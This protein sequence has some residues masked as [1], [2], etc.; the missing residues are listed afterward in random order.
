M[1]VFDGKTECIGFIFGID[2]ALYGSLKLF[3][4][5]CSI[6]SGSVVWKLGF[7]SCISTARCN[8]SGRNNNEIKL[9]LFIGL[10][11]CSY[12]LNYNSKNRKSQKRRLLEH[13]LHICCYLYPLLLNKIGFIVECSTI[14]VSYYFKK[15]LKLFY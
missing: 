6:D 1:S 11:S 12:I 4:S 15:T 9:F 10:S 7:V 8:R 3:F 2:F 5:D 14:F 13:F